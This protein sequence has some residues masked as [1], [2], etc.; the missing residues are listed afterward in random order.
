MNRYFASAAVFVASAAVLV[1]EIVAGRILAPYVGVSL[2][3]FTG[4]IGTI[5]AAIAVGAWLGG[6]AADRHDPARL[7]GPI[8]IVGGILAVVSPALVYILGPAT[9]GEGPVTI[10][11]LA[12]VGFFLPAAVLS[13]VTPVVA[14]A[15]LGS[16]DETG[17]V[18]GQLSAIGTAGALFGTFVTGFVLIAA[19]PSQPITWVVG[20]VLVLLGGLQML[21]IG[22][23]A[24]VSTLVILAVSIAASA[25]VAAPCDY[26]TAYSCAVVVEQSDGD[27]RMKALVLDTFVNSVVDLDDPTFLASR[28]ARVVDAVVSSRSPGGPR[29]VVYIGGGAMTLPRH[30]H[31]SAGSLA[32]VLELDDLVPQIAVDDLGLEPGPWLKVI[33][34][35]AR[36]TLSALA[37]GQFDVAVGDAFSGRSVPWHLT[38]VEFV[39]DV[40]AVLEPGGLYVMNVIDHPP[41]GFVKA[42]AVTLLAVFD[43]V[44]VVAPLEYLEGGR[45]GNFVL[46]GSND[47]IEPPAIAAHLVDGEE[48]IVDGTVADWAGDATALTDR[49]APVDQILSRP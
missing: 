20:V 42:E 18:V 43:H 29:N 45:G 19:M 37:E 36:V 21:G 31:E 8:L 4:I 3:T 46:V 44:A 34:G 41:F 5:L 13:A 7:L 16:L 40:Q 15:L 10:V 35:D 26:E 49:F 48:V 25:A 38:T 39:E 32:V 33:P 2:Q 14:K 1:L 12:A 6:R 9:A 11:F 27:R 47:S 30:Y 24:T 17:S 28:Y 22:Q 23:R